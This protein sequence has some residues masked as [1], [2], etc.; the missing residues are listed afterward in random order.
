M[1]IISSTA[2]TLSVLGAGF[3]FL[4]TGTDAFTSFLDTIFKCRFLSCWSA[5][6][7][8][9]RSSCLSFFGISFVFFCDFLPPLVE[10]TLKML[11]A[12]LVVLLADAFWAACF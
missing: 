7:L 8:V 11:V 5:L 12:F 4:P 6:S 10:A 3:F 2:W 9:F 1:F